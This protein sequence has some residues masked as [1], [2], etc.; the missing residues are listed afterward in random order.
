MKHENIEPQARSL[1]R[2]LWRVGLDAAKF[3]AERNCSCNEKEDEDNRTFCFFV[4]NSA[5]SGVL[6]TDT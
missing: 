3:E 2:S 1:A 5:E 6:K 4:L